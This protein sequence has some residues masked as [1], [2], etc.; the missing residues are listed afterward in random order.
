MTFMDSLR[1]ML[2][3]NPAFR[4]ASPGGIVPVLAPPRPQPADGSPLP[5]LTT[6]QRVGGSSKQTF[7]STGPQRLR[8]QFDFH[9]GTYELAEAAHQALRLSLERYQ[10]ILADGTYLQQAVYLQ[11]IDFY[12]YEPRQF[13]CACEFYLDFTLN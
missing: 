10:G 1:Q 2:W 5:A 12:D 6:F 3:E 8:V 11:P 9:A 13:R 7:D 4:E